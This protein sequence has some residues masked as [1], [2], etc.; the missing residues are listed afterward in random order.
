MSDN[1][2]QASC[3]CGQ[4]SLSSTQPVEKTAICHCIACKKRTGSNYGVQARLKKASCK[5]Q[6]SASTYQRTGDEGCK[7]DYSFCP[8]CGTTL[9]WKI[10][11]MPDEII[12]A[13]GTIDHM[14]IP[15][16]TF[17]VYEERMPSW[18][19]IPETVTQRMA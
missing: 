19:I 15:A 6:G 14:E 10:D 5:V 13:A 16:P 4:L 7:I 18:N 1:Q 3:C 12:L 9:F 8:N 2:I 11:A 17:S